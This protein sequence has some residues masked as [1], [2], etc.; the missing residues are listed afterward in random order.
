VS[1]GGPRPTGTCGVCGR[2]GPLGRVA[3]GTE[4]ALCKRCYRP[5]QPRRPCG[6][7]GK[8]KVVSIRASGTEPD[9]CGECA[10]RREAPC[11]ICG[12][13]GPLALKATEGS[14]AVGRCCYGPPAATCHVCGRERPCYHAAGPAPICP[15]CASAWRASVCLDCGRER[16]AARRVE[17]GV[18]CQGCAW[19]RGGV[20][21]RCGS[22]ARLR[23]GLCGS[24]ALASR[25]AR[26]SADADPA[27]AQALGPYLASLL[28]RPNPDSTL[29]WTSTPTFGLVRE[30]L[31]G[32]VGISHVALDARA[33]ADGPPS[34]RAVAF[35]RA[36]LVDAGVLEGRDEPVRL[37]EEWLVRALAV[38]PEGRDRALVEA[39]AR[40]EVAPRLSGPP[41]FRRTRPRSPQKWPRSLVARAIELAAWLGAQGLGLADLRQ[42]RLDAWIAAGN[43]TRRQARLFVAWLERSGAAPPLRVEWP[44]RGPSPARGV[45]APPLR[46]A[47][48]PQRR[49]ARRR[50]RH[51]RRRR[52]DDLARSWGRRPAGPPGGARARSA[53]PCHRPR[54]RAGMAPPGPHRGHPPLRRNAREPPPP[55]P[56]HHREGGTPGRPARAPRP[57]AGTDP[58]RA[59]R[60][61]PGTRGQVGARGGEDLRRLCGAAATMISSGA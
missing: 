6:R 37:F 51:R 46:P 56:R 7:C 26:L 25:L 54:R 45:P 34:P 57:P 61:P 42:D 14:P 60:L 4:P 31:A 44:D 49:P 3:R 5:V 2:E 43:T 24:C 17:G 48:H 12:K 8:V 20:C 22:T 1:E 21:A 13:V 38:L 59:P 47:A 30:M 58:R 9:I 15:S 10:P 16:R 33:D 35:L 23:V 18:L 39:Y 29:R 53:R 36:G 50:H 40:W 27:A 32:Q 55:T 52:G 11:G 41:A 28:K 19:R